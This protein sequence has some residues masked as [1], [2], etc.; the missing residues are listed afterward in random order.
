MTLESVLCF[1]KALSM[2]PT[3]YF[4]QHKIHVLYKTI[5]YSN[6]QCMIKLA[7]DPINQEDN[8]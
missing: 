5:L 7:F 2:V 4:S 3:H 8:Y 6:E 1:N